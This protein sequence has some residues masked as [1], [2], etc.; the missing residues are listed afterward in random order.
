[1]E[2]EISLLLSS[3]SD[4]EIHQI[5][6]LPRNTV[7]L[8]LNE[9]KLDDFILE[10]LLRALKSWHSAKN[11][12][13]NKFKIRLLPDKQQH[14]KMELMFSTLEN[15][16]SLLKSSKSEIIS[17]E[18]AK[19]Y[20]LSKFKDIVSILDRKNKED[21]I[22]QINHFIPYWLTHRKAPT[23]FLLNRKIL[24]EKEKFFFYIDG[25]NQIPMESLSFLQQEKL[26]KCKVVNL[27]KLEN[28]FF[29]ELDEINMISNKNVR[30]DIQI[31]NEKQKHIKDT[32]NNNKTKQI[33][34][35]M[36][37]N[38]S[39]SESYQFFNKM[40]EYISFIEKVNRAF[41]RPDFDRLEGW[42]TQ[43]GLPSL[44]KRR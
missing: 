6:D 3:L 43:G 29:I 25:L 27:I 16:S 9:K 24:I 44:G 36:H 22:H 34:N 42:H 28:N 40:K 12:A 21:F 17:Y 11:R 8:L 26:S 15:I 38:F 18:G 5:C 33:K 7:L 14:R 2:R 30:R 41:V 23:S 10:R 32:Y 20:L 37:N 1:M 39:S 31:K 35:K 4:N 13:G 19:L